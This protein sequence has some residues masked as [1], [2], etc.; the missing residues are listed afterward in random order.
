MSKEPF[1]HSIYYD[2]TNKLKIGEQS[3]QY[4]TSTRKIEQRNTKS[5]R[6]FS[7]YETLKG[8]INSMKYFDFFRRLKNGI[9]Q[10]RK[11]VR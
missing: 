3:V 10:K 9:N 5:I 7:S 2:L 11:N 6:V 8:E 4:C 1:N